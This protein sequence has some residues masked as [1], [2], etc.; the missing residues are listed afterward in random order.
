MARLGPWD[1]EGGWW[2]RR[3][4]LDGSTLTPLALSVRPAKVGGHVVDAWSPDGKRLLGTAKG[5]LVDAMAAGLGVLSDQVGGL[6][7]TRMSAGLTG[8]LA[9]DLPGRVVGVLRAAKEAGEAVVGPWTRVQRAAMVAGVHTEWQ[10]EWGGKGRL[11][12][13]VVERANGTW[14]PKVWG[15]DGQRLAMPEDILD[16]EGKLLAYFDEVGALAA[17]VHALEGSLGR[18]VHPTQGITS[19]R[20]LELAPRVSDLVEG[21]RR[22]AVRRDPAAVIVGEEEVRIVGE[23]DNER[24]DRLASE[25][26]YNRLAAPA[27]AG[28]TLEVAS[29]GEVRFVKE[30]RVKAARASTSTGLLPW[31]WNSDTREY[32]RVHAGSKLLAARVESVNDRKKGGVAAV[33][34]TAFDA[35]GKVLAHGREEI[36]AGGSWAPA[37]AKALLAVE[38]AIGEDV[39]PTAGVHGHRLRK[40]LDAEMPVARVVA[41][42]GPWVWQPT[43]GMYTRSL[44]DGTPVMWVD[45]SL[46]YCLWDPLKPGAREPDFKGEVPASTT[47]SWTAAMA[48]A[49]VALEGLLGRELDATAGVHETSFGQSLERD[50]EL[51]RVK[52]KT[53]G[54]VEVPVEKARIGPWKWTGVAPNLSNRVLERVHAVGGRAALVDLKERSW[55][56]WDSSGTLVA[57]GVG[58]RLEDVVVEA[59]LAMD[60]ELGPSDAFGSGDAPNLSALSELGASVVKLLVERRMSVSPA[61]TI[62]PWRWSGERHHNP[63]REPGRVLVRKHE[64]GQVAALV[65]IRQKRWTVWD[66]AGRVV[67]SGVDA[68]SPEEAVV[69]ATLAMEREFGASEVFGASATVVDALL[70]SSELGMAVVKLL[71]ERRGAM[72]TKAVGPWRYVGVNEARSSRLLERTHANG[73]RAAIL[74]L[75]ERRWTVWDSRGNLIKGSSVGGPPED[76][77][78][79]VTNLMERE[80]G[81]SPVFGTGSGDLRSDSELARAAYG[82]QEAVAA[83]VEVLAPWQV[84][85]ASSEALIRP[86]AG[87][88]AGI[89]LWVAS[90]GTGWTAW[91][92][93]RTVIESKRDYNESGK[94]AKVEAIAAAHAA[95]EKHL[96]REVDPLPGLDRFGLLEVVTAAVG[97]RRMRLAA[98]RA[99]AS[100][101]TTEAP[102]GVEEV[103]VG[104]EDIFWSEGDGASAGALVMEGMEMGA[105]SAAVEAVAKRL[106]MKVGGDPTN[107]VG[108]HAA[109]MTIVLLA[110][111]VALPMMGKD[112]PG[113]EFAQVRL[114]RALTGVSA[115]AS[116]EAVT[117]LMGLLGPLV[118]AMA[119]GPEGAVSMLLGSTAGIDEEVAAY[120]RQ[121]AAAVAAEEVPARKTRAKDKVGART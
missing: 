56:V 117:T 76:L 116:A 16:S 49:H 14:A 54:P 58:G 11:A 90:D 15:A 102:E 79:E 71:A 118:A 63:T 75:E 12:V 107:P 86:Y 100:R 114:D 8:R 78:V 111:Q 28:E 44:A 22:E 115:T 66:P 51:R 53:E 69:E 31:V 99:E 73:R 110:R 30:A 80:F 60:R 84:H 62:E 81:V 93:D 97:L 95:L 113:K 17:A 61:K 7:G 36:A 108:V 120:Q 101:G 119:A 83:P 13:R 74:D 48:D 68:R 37:M 55:R 21:L 72:E 65:D 89:A 34:W 20:W 9:A 52:A 85:A 33:A 70:R 32:K 50:V 25:R 87:P 59:T 4:E 57:S 96:G 26:G 121:R 92:P 40:L 104:L 41:R 5:N 98:E 109:K 94:A 27:T 106:I 24:L 77:L 18:P 43:K 105:S 45:G 46:R 10:R 23:S 6:T 3:W 42:L 112:T 39:D 103:A 67:A 29:A 2:V 19:S 88:N 64:N 47:M 91:A 38:G 35:V 82:V 1:E